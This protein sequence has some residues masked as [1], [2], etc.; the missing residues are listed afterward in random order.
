MI[1]QTAEY[2]LRTIVWL[3]GQDGVPQTTRQIAAATRVPPGYL[4]KILQNLGRAGLVKS[5]RGIHGGFILAQDP[6]AISPLD[7]LNSIDPLRRI[8][9][10]PLGIVGHDTELCPL[11]RRLDDAMA[12]IESVLAS[13]KISE[14]V[15]KT[16]MVKS[17]C[18][19]A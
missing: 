17:L 5:Q 13:T 15:A 8:E 18:V 4:S 11:H 3:A 6:H 9:H 7:V 1:S 16:H 2:A 19:E 14:L 10:C 12:H